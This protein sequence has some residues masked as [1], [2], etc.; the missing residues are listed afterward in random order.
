[1]IQIERRFLEGQPVPG[2]SLVVGSRAV[3][4]KNRSTV[5]TGFHR[6]I[7]YLTIRLALDFVPCPPTMLTL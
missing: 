6:N 3:L 7:F 4:E 1:M 5:G 2:G